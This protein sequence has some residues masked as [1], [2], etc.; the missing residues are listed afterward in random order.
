MMKQLLKIEEGAQL[1][2]AIVGMNLLPFQFSWYVWVVLFLMPDI[3]MLGYLGGPKM[4]AVTYNLVH[5]KA[6]GALLFLGGLYASAPVFCLAGVLLFGHAAFD[7]MLGYG[8]KFSDSF[9]HTHL[10]KIGTQK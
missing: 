1:A 2:A 5:H 9:H 3:S 8:L 7:R 4:G 6:S 10:G